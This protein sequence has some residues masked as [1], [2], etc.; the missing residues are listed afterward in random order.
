MPN[1]MI[2]TVGYRECIVHSKIP[3]L[4][5]KLFGTETWVKEFF[6]AIQTYSRVSLEDYKVY[7][8]CVTYD[9]A[10]RYLRM[11][12][13]HNVKIFRYGTKAV[14]MSHIDCSVCYKF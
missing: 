14:F 6:L 10:I 7:S 4:P 8:T 9:D 1:K 5:Y 2:T 3:L 13:P 11:R 12:I